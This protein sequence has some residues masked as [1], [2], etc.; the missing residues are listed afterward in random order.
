MRCSVSILGIMLLLAAATGLVY[1]IDKELCR[2]IDYFQGQ[3][4][5]LVEQKE[6]KNK[7][8]TVAA[9]AAESDSY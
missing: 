9:R 5:A 8:I 1:G 2:A 3:I 6:R 4:R 7:R